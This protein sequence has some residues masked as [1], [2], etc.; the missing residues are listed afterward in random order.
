MARV[1]TVVLTV[2]LTSDSTL[3]TRCRPAPTATTLLLQS[4]SKFG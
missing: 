4:V 2:A 3:A 1:V